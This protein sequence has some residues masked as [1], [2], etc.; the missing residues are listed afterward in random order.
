[1]TGKRGLSLDALEKIFTAL[2]LRVSG[3]DAPPAEAGGPKRGK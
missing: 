3:P 2:R 1:M